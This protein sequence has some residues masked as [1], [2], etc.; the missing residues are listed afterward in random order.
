ML[1]YLSADDEVFCTGTLYYI[2][3]ISSSRAFRII[4][5]L[6]MSTR[7]ADTSDQTKTKGLLRVRTAMSRG[8]NIIVILRTPVHYYIV[9]VPITIIRRGHS[10]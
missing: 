8:Y 5:I 2:L 1:Y 9:L 10:S 7:M 4:I 6:Y 3:N